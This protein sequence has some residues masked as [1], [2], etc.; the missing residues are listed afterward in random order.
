MPL[1]EAMACE[2]PIVTSDLQ[3]MPEV[4]NGAARFVNPFDVEDIT[5][6]IVEVLTDT[7]LRGKLIALGRKRIRDFSWEG[8]AQATLQAF[9]IAIRD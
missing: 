9:Q 5:R 6:G 4:A 1:L 7:G 8:A 3:A 2:V